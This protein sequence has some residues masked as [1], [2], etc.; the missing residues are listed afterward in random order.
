MHAPSWAGVAR[1]RLNPS[2]FTETPV[3]QP[4]AHSVADADL[5]VARRVLALE[6][7]ALSALAKSLDAAF[8]RAVDTILAVEGRVIVSGMGKSGHVGHKIAATLASTGT[9]SQFVHP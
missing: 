4:Q 2:V 5:Q 6:S 7:D 1:N 8:A 3:T 9:P